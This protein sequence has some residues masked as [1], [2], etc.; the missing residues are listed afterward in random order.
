[1]YNLE[2]MNL[3]IFRSDSLINPPILLRVQ[4]LLGTERPQEKESMLKAENCLYEILRNL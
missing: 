3:I 4:Y 1:M 2:Y